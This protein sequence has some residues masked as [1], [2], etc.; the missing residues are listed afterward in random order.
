MFPAP[1]RIKTQVDE[2][3][4]LSEDADWAE[5]QSFMDSPGQ[6]SETDDDMMP[7]WEQYADLGGLTDMRS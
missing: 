4:I 7:A 3:Y 1:L 2:P 6:M 5:M